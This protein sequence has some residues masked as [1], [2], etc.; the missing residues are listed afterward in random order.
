M[1]L[2]VLARHAHSELNLAHRI[3]GDPSVPVVWAAIDCSGAYAI[4]SEGRGETVLGRMAA[5]IERLPRPDELERR[6]EQILA[7]DLNALRLRR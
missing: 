7:D 2:Y 5:R 4:G 1:P 6:S 3:N